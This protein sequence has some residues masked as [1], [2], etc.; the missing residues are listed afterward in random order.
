MN[1]QRI[2]TST[3][4]S[5]AVLLALLMVTS[6]WVLPSVTAADLDGDGTDDHLDDCP[7]A[8][9]N[10]TV[11]RTGCPDR[12]GDGTSDINDRWTMGTAGFA[13]DQYGSNSENV[14]TIVYNPDGTQFVTGDD[15]GWVRVYNAANYQNM[16][17]VRVQGQEILDIDW[18]DDGNWIAATRSDDQDDPLPATGTNR[19]TGEGAP[20]LDIA[21]AE[22]PPRHGDDDDEGGSGSD[23]DCGG[24]GGGD[25]EVGRG[26]AEE[27]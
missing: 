8:W 25:R 5:R 2:G 21:A 6:L 15:D 11:D 26:E 3:T 13:Q 14:N 18:S 17:S 22:M 19:V 10:S 24:S 16:R 20:R 4:A 23:E 9:G 1:Q 12:D 7:I 27:P